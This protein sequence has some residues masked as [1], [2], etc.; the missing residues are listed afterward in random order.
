MSDTFW[1]NKDG[2]RVTFGPTEVEVRSPS[3]LKEIY[4]DNN[5]NPQSSPPASSTTSSGDPK[6]VLVVSGSFDVV[7]RFKDSE[8]DAPADLIVTSDT[9]SST[10]SWQSQ[11][12]VETS[13]PATTGRK[14]HKP[15][16]TAYGLGRNNWRNPSNRAKFARFNTVVA[17]FADDWTG[18]DTV[19]GATL[20]PA[21][22][23]YDTQ[24]RAVNDWTGHP[25]EWWIHDNVNAWHVSDSVLT[26]EFND[27]ARRAEM[28]S[29]NRWG[30]LVGAADTP[31]SLTKSGN[32]ITAVMNSP[33]FYM[34]EGRPIY[35]DHPTIPELRVGSPV[36]SVSGNSFQFDLRSWDH[37][38]VPD[39]P[40]NI[41]SGVTI[42]ACGNTGSV[43]ST[44]WTNCTSNCPSQIWPTVDNNRYVWDY[45]AE[46]TI[47]NVLGLDKG[48]TNGAANVSDRL[49][50]GLAIQQSGGNLR[51]CFTDQTRERAPF[52]AKWGPNGTTLG[53]DAA[54]VAFREG[55]VN[56]RDALVARAAQYGYAIEVGAN[57]EPVNPATGGVDFDVDNPDGLG[58]ND[59]YRPNGLP[60]YAITHFEH[61]FS[62]DL[63]FTP[64]ELKP[65]NNQAKAFRDCLGQGDF[66]VQSGGI[67]EEGDFNYYVN[68]DSVNP[69]NTKQQA[70]RYGFSACM[71]AANGDGTENPRIYPVAH[72]PDEGTHTA[73][74]WYDE[75]DFG[76]QYPMNSDGEGYVKDVFKRGITSGVYWVFDT[77][78]D[79]ISDTDYFLSLV[80]PPGN[81][82]TTFDIQNLID[83]ELG[84]QIPRNAVK[85]GTGSAD[86]RIAGDG[87]NDGSVITSWSS[88]PE[89]KGIT[90]AVRRPTAG[91]ISVL[92]ALDSGPN[93]GAV[94]TPADYTVSPGSNRLLILNLHWE[95][96]S[97][98]TVTGVTYGGQ[99]MTEVRAKV[100]VDNGSR[101]QAIHSWYLNDAG[102][103]AA[104]DDSF[105]VSMSG[106]PLD[107]FYLTRSYQNVNQATPIEDSEVAT[108]NTGTVLNSVAFDVSD[109][110]YGV[111]IG[112]GNTNN[113]VLTSGNGFAQLAEGQYAEPG[114][115]VRYVYGEKSYQADGTDTGSITSDTNVRLT[116]LNYSINPA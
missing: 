67:S 55:Q 57:M 61:T 11:S 43:T 94:S 103:T 111:Q 76:G 91:S 27:H 81:G 51:G 2:V 110:G 45:I 4:E 53:R 109:G 62:N 58:S 89:R 49:N 31:V 7:S 101:W 92:D 35:L 87:V 95:A 74:N 100:S 25:I 30:V 52:E 99:A 112:G 40:I 114:L 82:T 38:V 28:I 34:N 54:A 73:V 85:M 77:P 1:D 9:F 33:K 22:I 42:S 16:L 113:M 26:S 90:V 6:T 84:T 98:L 86:G 8:I 3:E 32:T 66:A 64:Q 12:I 29:K 20:T 59:Q 23:I 83:T 10:S 44:P 68:N 5:D 69:S 24:T 104:T 21:D 65:S 75:H 39:G 108:V 80:N 14:T 41:T 50:I 13:T 46:R 116:L 96:A 97:D 17:A 19:S 60:K 102:I 37:Q 79:D 56:Y 71:Y 48:Y 106:T 18:V 36:N 63:T 88:I 72:Q 70:N 93:N 78:R 107:A 115:S 15:R 105:V 47:E